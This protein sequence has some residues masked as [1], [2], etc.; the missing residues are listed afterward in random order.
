MKQ[1]CEPMIQLLWDIQAAEAH[2]EKAADAVEAV[3]QENFHRD[4]IRTG[5]FTESLKKYCRDQR[6]R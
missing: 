2:F 4:H 3:A 6:G 5:Q 1:Y